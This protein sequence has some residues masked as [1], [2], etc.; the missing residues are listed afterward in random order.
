M[1]K[2]TIP[3]FRNPKT[4]KI[5]RFLP[6]YVKAMQSFRSLDEMLELLAGSEKK[7]FKLAFKIRDLIIDVDRYWQRQQK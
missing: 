6:D 4:G 1:G 2:L 5:E 3:E 7:A